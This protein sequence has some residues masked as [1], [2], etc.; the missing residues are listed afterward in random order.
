VKRSF[1]SWLSRFLRGGV[2]LSGVE[3]AV[4]CELVA[5]LPGELRAIVSSQFDEY[6]LVQRE[7]DGRALNFY[8]LDRLR[9]SVTEP[10]RRLDL[11]TNEAPLIRIRIELGADREPL[12]A[13]LGAV[14]GHASRVA[15]SRP[16]ASDHGIESLKVVGAKDAWRSNVMRDA[17]EQDAGAQ[18]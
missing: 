16:V 18:P 3:H 15:F 5:R 9:G 7:V 6:N 13:V 12:D 14:N 17:A 2:R 10:S 11:K 4:L 8:C 1:G